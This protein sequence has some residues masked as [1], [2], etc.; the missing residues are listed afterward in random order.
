MKLIQ[1]SNMFDQHRFLPFCF[2]GIFPIPK[3]VPFWCFACVAILSLSSDEGICIE[4]DDVVNTLDL[5]E[6]GSKV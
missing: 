3:T 2:G 1:I 4:F 5:D 6:G